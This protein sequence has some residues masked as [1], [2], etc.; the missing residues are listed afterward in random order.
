MATSTRIFSF[1]LG[2]APSRSLIKGLARTTNGRFVFIPPSTNV[3]VYVGEQL[4][5]A[6]QPCITNTKIKLNIDSA[7]IN[8]VPT[9]VPPVFINERVLIYALMKDNKSTPF[10]H[11]VSV[12][13]Y[14]DQ[15]RLGEVKINRIPSVC[16]DGTIARLA[17]KALIL[18]LQH[19]KIPSSNDES[20]MTKETIR[21]R[22]IQIS[23]E[24]NI[25][26]PFTAFVGVEKR[27]NTSNADMVLREIPIE[28]SADNQYLKYL[29][30]KMSEMRHKQARS[31]MSYARLR[32]RDDHYVAKRDR[33]HREYREAERRLD[34]AQN[35]YA[36]SHRRYDN[37]TRDYLEA[38]D[39][40][41]TA[42][43]N[44]KHFE[45]E[46]KSSS[47]VSEGTDSQHEKAHAE[48]LLKKAVESL[49]HWEHK[50]ASAQK[51]MMRQN[52]EMLSTMRA[53]H[54]VNEYLS[55]LEHEDQFD[56]MH[57]EMARARVDDDYD[58]DLSSQMAYV[59]AL[60][61]YER[62]KQSSK[63]SGTVVRNDNQDEQNIVRQLIH[64]Q[65][66]DGLWDVDAKMIVQLTGKP[67]SDFPQSND[68]TMLMSAIIIVVLE[69]RFILLSSMWFGI[70]QKARKRLIDM[71]DKD[72]K[73][74]DALLDNIR[75]QL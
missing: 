12:E 32:D 2:H 52:D 15:K 34:H 48:M 45:D 9:N 19:A 11:N 69:T 68:T 38:Q 46:T 33:Y 1:G 66:F 43:Q 58:N 42:Q 67:L 16:D 49:K 4:Q 30:T 25:L 28:L 35:R 37:V 13:L 51:S 60:Q 7:L 74:L 14:S 27:V 62:E 73:Q 10:D 3:D 63:K 53:V 6:L 17:A 36:E 72:H 24:H 75:K 5:K 56:Q 70:V 8:I 57:Y 61:R 47:T 18:E 64:Q 41:E 55:R 71:L 54:E 31:Q 29:E 21:E 59:N 50:K 65:K 22:I 20:Q 26:S 39:D 44:L 40:Y 23:L